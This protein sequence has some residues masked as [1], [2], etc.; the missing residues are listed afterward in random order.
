MPKAKVSEFTKYVRSKI[1][2]AYLWGGQGESLFGLVKKLAKQNRQTDA[3]TEQMISFMKSKGVKDMEFFDCS[4]LGVSYLL[5][6]GAISGD[7]TADG[8]YRKCKKIVKN[9]VQEGD[10]AFLLNASGKATHIGYL[11]DRK[12][13]VHAFNQSRGVIQEDIG[14]QKWVFGRP[15]FCLEYDLK[16]EKKETSSKDLKIGDRITVKEPV[17]GYNTAANAKSGTNPTVTYPAGEYYV[18]RVYSGTTNIT[19]TKGTPGAWVVL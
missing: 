7:M 1:G 16:E 8:I 12:T 18:Y 13:V 2:T 3:K 9:D 10:M 11:V 6:V 19:R 5:S 14:K 15:E 4:G 17:L